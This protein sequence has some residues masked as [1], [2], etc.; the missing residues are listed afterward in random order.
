MAWR[1]DIRLGREKEYSVSRSARQGTLDRE[2]QKGKLGYK[3]GSE[4]PRARLRN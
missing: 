2:R 3:F 4:V 1:K